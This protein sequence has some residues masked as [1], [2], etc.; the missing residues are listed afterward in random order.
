MLAYK[1][2]QYF[3]KRSDGDKVSAFTPIKQ[4]SNESP[5]NKIV[6]LPILYAPEDATKNLASPR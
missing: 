5:H 2:I 6:F 4:F 1:K 3:I